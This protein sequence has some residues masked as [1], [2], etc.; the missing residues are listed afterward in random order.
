MNYTKTS[1][2]GE[3][4]GPGTFDGVFNMDRYKTMEQAIAAN[5]IVVIDFVR[6]ENGIINFE[7]YHTKAPDRKRYWPLDV[8]HFDQR[9][10]DA[11]DDE[12]AMQLGLK[13][14]QFF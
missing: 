14:L 5:D 9:G 13:I 4:K 8:Q 3:R 10:V 11:F 6:D 2:L 1:P 12:V 7:F